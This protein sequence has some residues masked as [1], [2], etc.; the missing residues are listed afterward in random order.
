MKNFKQHLFICTNNR[1]S[2]EQSCGGSGA[3]ELLKYAKEQGTKLGFKEKNIR[4]SSSGCLGNC[5]FGPVMVIYPQGKWYTCKTKEEIDQI[6][7]EIE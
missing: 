6:L 4:I 2:G 7:S 5:K 3:L 1:L